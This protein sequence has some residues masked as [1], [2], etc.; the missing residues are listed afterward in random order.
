[1][2]DA[3]REKVLRVPLTPD[4]DRAVREKASQVGSPI[5]LAAK[6]NAHATVD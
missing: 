1:M 6:G 3:K 4:E 5:A 2:S